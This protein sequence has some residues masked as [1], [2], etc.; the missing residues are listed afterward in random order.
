ME[1]PE[2]SAV[3]L[4]SGKNFSSRLMSE[5]PIHKNV[6]ST[7]KETK[8]WI[9]KFVVICFYCCLML[10]RSAQALQKINSETA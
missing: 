6:I 3:P 10:F 1:A 5:A 2:A 9:L 8:L 4:G 7:E